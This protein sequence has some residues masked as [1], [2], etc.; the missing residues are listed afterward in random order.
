MKVTFPTFGVVKMQGKRISEAEKLQDTRDAGEDM[1][2][3]M[4]SGHG[5]EPVY[6]VMPSPKAGEDLAVTGGGDDCGRL[7]RPSTGEEVA[8]LGG[9]NESVCNVGF[10]SDGELIATAAL[11][12]IV[13]IW[14]TA[15]TK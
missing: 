9:H 11:D 3:C 8:V 2:I 4:F 1:S 5:G 6:D 12:G 10:S 7:F 14:D 13:K 15:E